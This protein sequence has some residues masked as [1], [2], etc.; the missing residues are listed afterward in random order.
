MLKVH[1]LL[2]AC[3]CIMMAMHGEEAEG[4]AICG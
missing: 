1:D 4:S 3:V 2:R